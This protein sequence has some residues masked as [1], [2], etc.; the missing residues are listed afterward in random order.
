MVVCTLCFLFFDVLN[1]CE[2][3]LQDKPSRRVIGLLE[4]RNL[5]PFE[6]DQMKL[7]YLE[8]AQHNEFVE[9][10]NRILKYYKKAV[11]EYFDID[12]RIMWQEDE[13][14]ENCCPRKQQLLKIHILYKER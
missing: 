11:K 14:K 1:A 8:I 4:M 5:S 9:K 2:A 3:T 12:D 6:R 10:Y 7:T 13:L